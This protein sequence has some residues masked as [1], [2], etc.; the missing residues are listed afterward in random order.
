MLVRQLRQHHDT[1]GL[2]KRE[3]PHQRGIG[4][5]ED[6]AVD[7]DA[8]APGRRAAT[9]AKNRVEINLPPRAGGTVAEQ[10]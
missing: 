1:L 8:E 9:T 2:A 6:G 3:R 10:F 4:Q 5:R 7:A